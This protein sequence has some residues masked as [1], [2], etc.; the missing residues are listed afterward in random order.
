MRRRK[1]VPDLQVFE[2]GLTVYNKFNQIYINAVSKKLFKYKDPYVTL[3]I[4]SSPSFTLFL[5]VI[6]I[7]FL[8]TTENSRVLIHKLKVVKKIF[9]KQTKYRPTK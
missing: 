3:R 6:G 5:F 2:R 1:F 7:Y 8:S 4:Y 9:T